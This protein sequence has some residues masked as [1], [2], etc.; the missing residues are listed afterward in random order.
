M[1]NEV[2][3]L[4]SIINKGKYKGKTISEII[5]IDRK[6]MINLFKKGYYF[7]DEVMEKSRFKRVIRDVKCENVIAEHLEKDTKVYT[8]DTKNIN[9]I[10]KDIL[11]LD[12]T[13]KDVDEKDSDD[14]EEYSEDSE[15]LD[16]E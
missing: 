3:T 8:T 16:N 2:L 13:Y 15:G 14:T 9:E 1:K 6:E 12:N 4:N 5:D 7:D 10:L 11:T